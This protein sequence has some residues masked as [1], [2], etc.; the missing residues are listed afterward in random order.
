MQFECLQFGY[1]TSPTD[2]MNKGIILWQDLVQILTNLDV[3]DTNNYGNDVRE[4]TPYMSV[5]CACPSTTTM[6][7]Q[8]EV[9]R[10]C[11]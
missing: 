2:Y 3:R 6:L 11:G 10:I 1:V 7:R 5:Y 4:S 8:A 9:P